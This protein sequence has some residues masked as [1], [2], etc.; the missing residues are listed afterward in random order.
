MPTNKNF[1][2][3]FGI[4]FFLVTI[5]LFIYNL[6]YLLLFFLGLIFLFLGFINSKILYPLNFLWFKFGILLSKLISPIIL[7]FMF[8]I[9]ISPY[10]IIVRLFNKEIREIKTKKSGVS[11]DTYWNNSETK[12]SIN[13]DNQY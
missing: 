3:T 12:N 2:I 13:F 8:Y 5:F 6:P 9:I 7:F 1:G 4:I 10:A 11:G